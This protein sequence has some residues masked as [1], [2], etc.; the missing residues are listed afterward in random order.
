MCSGGDGVAMTRRIRLLLALYA[1]LVALVAIWR[2]PTNIPI[3]TPVGPVFI[4]NGNGKI[5]FEFEGSIWT[6]NANGSNLTQ[7]PAGTW[8]GFAVSPDGKQIALDRT[9]FDGPSGLRTSPAS[10]TAS[11]ASPDPNEASCIS[12]M[13]TDGSDQRRLL[14][15]PA[16]LPVWSPDGEQIAFMDAGGFSC[17]IFVMNADGSGAP[18]KLRTQPNERNTCVSIS[19]WSP[20]G[21]KMA[22]QVS[23][24]IHVIDVSGRGEDKNQSL[25]LTEGPES[26]HSP[27]WSPNGT[28]IAFVR[29]SEIQ[30]MNTDGSEVTRLTHGPD[31]DFSP[32]WSPDGKQIAYVKQ[33][34]AGR[35]A[36]YT[37]Y[38][39]G[40]NPTVVRK[41]EATNTVHALDW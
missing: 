29:N 30:K 14:D 7:L 40:S 1:V 19:T 13:N 6:I 23:N 24:Q 35:S 39:D 11:A 5:F 26:N 18:T 16:A 28:E 34:A 38:S 12:V 17:D 33:Y 32:A 9:C 22:G 31:L 2:F 21:D 20:D 3:A 10:A 8:E 27:E 41:F 36:I 15:Q 37:M 4:P 25:K